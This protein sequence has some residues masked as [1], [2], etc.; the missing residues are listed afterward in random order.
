MISPFR[1]WEEV[2]EAGARTKYLY[3]IVLVSTLKEYN[4]FNEMSDSYKIIFI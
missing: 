2:A 4:R 3:S 1:H